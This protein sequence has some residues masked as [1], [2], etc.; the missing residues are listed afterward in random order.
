MIPY[1][2]KKH[3]RK[4]TVSRVAFNSDL[5]FDFSFPDA[6]NV[7]N[8]FNIVS[9]FR[10]FATI[11]TPLSTALTISFLSAVFNTFSFPLL[12]NNCENFTSTLESLSTNSVATNSN[13]KPNQINRQAEIFLEVIVDIFRNSVSDL[14]AVHPCVS[15]LLQCMKAGWRPSSIPSVQFNF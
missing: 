7:S 3:N 6:Q 10:V 1:F 14:T 5:S 11:S 2:R 12:T 9:P 15:G 4:R 8:D 13:V